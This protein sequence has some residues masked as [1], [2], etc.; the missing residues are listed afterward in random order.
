MPYASYTDANA[1][2]D[3]E[4]LAFVSDGDAQKEAASAERVIRGELTDRYGIV[5]IDDWVTTTPELIKT[6]AALLMASYRYAKVYS[7]AGLG[8]S[9][10]ATALEQRAL[11]LLRGLREGTIDIGDIV[12]VVPVGALGFERG[13]FFPDKFYTNEQG[14]PIRAF[15]ME[16]EF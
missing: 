13:D 5:V 1:W 7:E 11:E 3:E 15:S 16:M 8:V 9:N 10:Y 6:I 14:D 4:K 12:G 2:L